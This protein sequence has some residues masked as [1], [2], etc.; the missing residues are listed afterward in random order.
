[1]TKIQKHIDHYLL[2]PDRFEMTTADA[3][4]GLRQ[5]ASKNR[6]DDEIRVM[7]LDAVDELLR[8]TP[9]VY[10]NQLEAY[11]GTI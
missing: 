1:M 3:V 5:I 6:T 8:S 10:E 2:A 11:K 9:H 7:A 4:A